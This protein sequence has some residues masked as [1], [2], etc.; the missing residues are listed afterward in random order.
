VS[1]TEEPDVGSSLVSSLVEIENIVFKG[2]LDHITELNVVPLESD[3]SEAIK[4]VRLRKIGT[5]VYDRNEDNLSKYNSVFSSLHS[6]NSSVSLIIVGSEK[7]VELYIGTNKLDTSNNT[8]GHDAAETLDAAIKGNF[9]GIDLG[10]NLFFDQIQD[11]LKPFL[12]FNSVSSVAGVPSLKNEDTTSF[13]QGIEKIVDGMKGRLYAAVIQASPVSRKQMELV[14]SSYAKLYS[15]LSSLEQM[16]ITYSE[17]SSV[18]I[19]ESIAKGITETFSESIGNSQTTTKGTS[20]SNSV[21]SS[22]TS[23]APDLKKAI[24]QAAAGAMTGGIAAAAVSGGMGAPAGAVIGAITGFGTGI[25]GGSKTESESETHTENSSMAQGV[26]NTSS[27]SNASS[28]TETATNTNTTSKGESIQIT[29]KNREITNY[30]EIIDDQLE[31]IKECKS[32]GMWNWSA[33]FLSETQI[34]AKLGADIYSGILRGES[35][36]LERNSIASWEKKEDTNNCKELINYISQLKHPVFALPEG[37]ETDVISHTSLISTKEMAIAM[38]LPQKSLPGIPVFDSIVF[39]R[40]VTSFDKKLDKT[41]NIGKI[42][43]FGML[44]SEYNVDLDLDSFTSHTFITGST[45]SG[46]SNSVY[47]IINSIYK[48]YKIPFLIIE[49]AKGEYKNVFGGI[50]NMSVL[51]TN[52]RLSELIKINPFSF[53]SEIHIIEHIDRLIEIL[54]AVWPMYSAMPAILKEAVESTYE[55]YGWDLLYSKCKYGDGIFPDFNDLLDVLPDVINNSDYS[56]EVKGNYAGALITRVKSLT[57][58][59]YKTLF[60]KEEI[61][62]QILFDKPCIIDLSRVGSSETK[63]LLMGIIFLKLQ[64]YRIAKSEGQNSE[65]K[66]ITVIEEAHNLLRKSVSSQGEETAN[67]QGKSVEMISNAIA[68]MRTYGEGFIIADQAPGLLDPSVI[69][70]TNTKIILRLPDLNDREMVGKAANLSDDQIQELSK[71]RRGCAAIYQNNW[72]E[73]VLC[74]FNH[75]K[76]NDFNP[77]EYSFNEKTTIDIKNKKTSFLKLLIEMEFS[78]DSDKTSKFEG[79]LRSFNSIFPIEVDKLV[80]KKSKPIRI[81]YDIIKFKDS[82]LKTEKNS[83]FDIWFRS[84][85]SNINEVICIEGQDEQFKINFQKILLNIISE[86]SDNMENKKLLIQKIEQFENDKVVYL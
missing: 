14:E 55:K 3:L 23:S 12:D 40:A 77:L 43:N 83:N 16:Q 65:L 61:S 57:N 60:Q 37:F 38:S 25:L 47:G 29:K 34:E 68:E 86:R 59:Y 51:G 35:T 8:H 79:E 9:P 50:K 7:L 42:S 84:L 5:I 1:F 67:L 49:P 33:Y 45:G 32:Y 48:D 2:A 22:R 17:N 20:S 21:S 6:C 75:F 72:L 53:S 4:Q 30:L 52:P 10:S 31:R 15:S 74:Q 46:K 44:D 39:G 13:S 27:E 54:N 62:S 81:I 18:A 19:G 78:K 11:V 85:F 41:I 73:P 58:G 82:L 64:E 80:V 56:N 36:G 76:E 69:R 71:L 26:T 24:T 66:H 63:S 28:E 70:N